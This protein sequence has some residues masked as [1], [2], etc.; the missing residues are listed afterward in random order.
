M[1]AEYEVL[2]FLARR[3]EVGL[4]SPQRRVWDTHRAYLEKV[5]FGLES[6]MRREIVWAGKPIVVVAREA[7]GRQNMKSWEISCKEKRSWAG[8]PYTRKR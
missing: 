7:M 1:E 3:K 8:K 2:R 6:P 5:K 4:E